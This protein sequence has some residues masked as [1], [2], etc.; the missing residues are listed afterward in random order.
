MKRQAA[1]KL[2]C[3]FSHS[4]TRGRH[5][6][7]TLGWEIATDVRIEMILFAVTALLYERK[8]NHVPPGPCPAARGY[9]VV[10]GDTFSLLP[11]LLFPL[12]L[13]GGVL[14][15]PSFEDRRELKK[16]TRKSTSQI[17]AKVVRNF[18]YGVVGTISP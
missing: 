6:A 4:A 9:R 8:R 15:V 18:A 2:L 13:C 17:F 14:G 10:S 16:T 3:E 1:R 12:V 7:I 11:S 5:A